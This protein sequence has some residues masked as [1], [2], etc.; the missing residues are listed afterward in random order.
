LQRELDQQQQHGQASASSAI[1]FRKL[2]SDRL[3]RAYHSF[4]DMATPPDQAGGYN[5]HP[6]SP[7]S[8]PASA[9]RTSKQQQQQQ[10]VCSLAG[11]GRLTVGGSSNS[12]SIGVRPGSAAARRTKELL[13]QAG[14]GGGSGAG[15]GSPPGGGT[16]RRPG[17]AGSGGMGSSGQL[18]GHGA[19]GSLVL[20]GP[21]LQQGLGGPVP[22]ARG[23]VRGSTD[24]LQLG[25]Q[26]PGS[27]GGLL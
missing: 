4:E 17:T 14:L 9:R 15:Q 1:D 16:L 18:R 11:G 10:L 3:Q 12:A 26:R 13:L 8:R 21:Q 19:G 6:H 7:G 25:G 24:A 2:D 27:R 23:L 5:S 22:R 20:S